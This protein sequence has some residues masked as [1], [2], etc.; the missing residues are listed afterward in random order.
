MRMC[1]RHG[2]PGKSQKQHASPLAAATAS[3][4]NVVGTCHLSFTVSKTIMLVAQYPAEGP[5]ILLLDLKDGAYRGGCMSPLVLSKTVSRR[6]NENIYPKYYFFWCLYEKN[7]AYHKLSSN[8]Y[9]SYILC[10]SFYLYKASYNLSAQE[11][12]ICKRKTLELH[13]V[14]LPQMVGLSSLSPP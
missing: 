5:G 1:F 8:S 10:F 11:T 12:Q 9:S 6:W 3:P 13:H 7:A 4:Q 2:L 14:F